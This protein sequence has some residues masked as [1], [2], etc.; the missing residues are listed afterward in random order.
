MALHNQLLLN[1]KISSPIYNTQDAIDWLASLVSKINMKIVQGPYSSYVDVPG[2][3]GATAAVI[4]ETSHI[5]FHI[6][7]EEDPALLQFDLYTC[8]TLDVNLVIK[9]LD[10]KFGLID[11]DYLVLEREKG[12]NITST[13]PPKFDWISKD[14]QEGLW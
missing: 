9:E 14:K 13:R 3:R 5:A 12:F 10:D 8:S 11:Y 1:A 4:I 7:D 6:W 2:N